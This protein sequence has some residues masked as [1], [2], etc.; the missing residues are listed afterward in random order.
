MR[1]LFAILLSSLAGTAAAGEDGTSLGK[2]LFERRWVQA[3]AS[4]DSTDGLGP[5]FNASAC[6]SCHKRGGAARFSNNDGVLGAGGFVV[7]LGDVQGRP[8]PWY[9]RQIQERAIPGLEPEARIFPRLEPAAALTR[10]GADLKINGPGLARDTRTEIHVA[11][12]LA[13]RGLIEQVSPDAILALADPDDRDGD[14][15][16]GRARILSDSRVGRF[17]LKATGAT[18][19]EQA[20]DAAAFDMGLSSPRRAVPFGDCTSAQTRCLAMATG[21][22]PDFDGEEISGEIVTML[23][24][25]VASL[26]R[27]PVSQDEDAGRVFAASGCAA[28]HRPQMAA[29]DGRSL[30]VYSDLLLHDMGEDLAGTVGDAFASFSEWRTAPLI[31]LAPHKGQRRYLHDGRAASVAEAVQWHGGEA[32]PAREAFNALGDADRARLIAYLESL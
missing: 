7:R 12:S 16:S 5:L 32:K 17:G 29:R 27:P 13:G 30:P 2:A 14:G 28:C 4:T 21:R 9:G 1:V 8:D 24:A 22:S 20:A 19:A 31:D 25:Y 18:I 11:P 3:P 10:M 26:K 23:S 15:I 6:D